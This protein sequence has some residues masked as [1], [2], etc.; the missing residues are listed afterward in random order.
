[1]GAEGSPGGRL[2][3][4]RKGYKAIGTKKNTIMGARSPEEVVEAMPDPEGEP[5]IRDLVKKPTPAQYRRVKEMTPGE[6][7]AE[8]MVLT[9]WAKNLSES[10]NY[11]GA[12]S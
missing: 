3:V 1:M 4:E 2:G 5:S 8:A 7:L 12:P 9:A 6:R 11:V 10:A